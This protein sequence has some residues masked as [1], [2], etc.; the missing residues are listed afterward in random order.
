MRAYAALAEEKYQLLTYP[1]LVNILPPAHQEIIAARYQSNCQGLNAL[2]DYQVINLW[3]V[4]AEAVFSRPIPSLLPFVPILKGGGEETAIREALQRLRQEQ[5]LDELE[6]LLA[7]FATFVLESELVQQIMRW[8]MTV[9][10]ESPWYRQIL[11]EGEKRGRQ[12]G[13]QEGLLSGIMTILEIKFGDEG[14]RLLPEIQQIESVEILANLL[15]ALKKV[16]SLEELRA[17]YNQSSENQATES[18]LTE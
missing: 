3:E 17:I 6:P 16:N 10:L 7:F 4:E 14:L 1:V 2:Q 5:K 13:R 11:Q 15:A 8:D 9:L 12:E 18:N